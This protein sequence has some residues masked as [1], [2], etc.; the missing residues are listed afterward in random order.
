VILGYSCVAHD[1]SSSAI[2]FL[3]LLVHLPAH[4]L[5][6]IEVLS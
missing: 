2:F 1:P 6:D 4:F 3:Y 5:R